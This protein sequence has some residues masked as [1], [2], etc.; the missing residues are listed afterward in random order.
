MSLPDPV[1]RKE[2]YLSKAAGGSG[3]VPPEPVTREEMYLNA[4]ASGGGSGGASSL[5]DLSDVEM[6][7]PIAAESLLIFRNGIWQ[8]K[9]KDNALLGEDADLA[10][11]VAVDDT[12]EFSHYP[13]IAYR[14]N[15][16][17]G[18][19]FDQVISAAIQAGHFSTALDNASLRGLV[20]MAS[21]RIVYNV[22]M[23]FALRNLDGSIKYSLALSG[24]SED[25]AIFSGI[26][27]A[28]AGAGVKFYRITMV[29]YAA[30]AASTATLAV[31]AEELT[32]LEISFD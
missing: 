27:S 16:Q 20:L 19:S 10:G 6:A 24:A 1:T 21:T 7:D 30:N 2:M 15:T 14:S 3:S 4:I 8:S 11:A 31:K 29:A 25:A 22:P 18:Q 13:P 9:R 12:G 32:D 17:F 26:V 28:P 23:Y 5:N